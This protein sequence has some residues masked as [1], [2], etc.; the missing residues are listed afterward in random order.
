MYI[1]ILGGGTWGIALAKLL[2]ENNHT[3]CVWSALANEI[4]TLASS[5]VHPN[6]PDVQLPKALRFT[7]DI[8]AEIGRASCRERV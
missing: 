4:E 8:E 2:S 1:A 6:L 5:Y 7:T 3:V